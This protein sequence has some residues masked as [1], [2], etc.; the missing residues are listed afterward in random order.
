MVTVFISYETT[1]GLEFAKHLQKALEK[2]NIS[3]F[4]AKENIAFG[5]DP[6]QTIL[7]N[8]KDCEFFVPIITIT[9]LKSP[10]VKK[11]F[12]MARDLQKYIIPCIKE[13]I[14]TSAKEEFKELS[15][16]QYLKF[17][18][19]E[20]I[21]N[22]A[23]E[24]ILKEKIQDYK[25]SLRKL[26]ERITR[27]DIIDSLLYDVVSAQNEI[28]FWLTEPEAD[29]NRQIVFRTRIEYLEKQKKKELEKFKKEIRKKGFPL[30][31]YK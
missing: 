5:K 2:C 24:T 20:D 26:K 8:I 6:E 11:E 25:D 30:M 18:T 12:Q 23:T 15:D 29:P 10:E 28:Y 7:Q 27:E 22:N 14:E 4:V 17:E 21:A 13:G 1:T 3:S 19:K 16:Y 31:A 9:A